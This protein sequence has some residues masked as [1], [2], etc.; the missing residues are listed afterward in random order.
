[1]D[2]QNGA[3][4]ISTPPHYVEVS[5]LGM[6]ST[7]YNDGEVH[8][9][10]TRSA[11]IGQWAQVEKKK[12]KNQANKK[13]VLKNASAE[14]KNVIS[15]VPTEICDERGQLFEKISDKELDTIGYQVDSVDNKETVTDEMG[16]EWEKIQV[17]LDTGAVDWVFKQDAAHGFKLKESAASKNNIP[18]FAANGTSIKKHGQR[19]CVGFSGDWVPLAVNVNV[20]EV[21][22]NLGGGMPIIEA[23]NRIVLDKDGSF[24]ENKR[25]GSRIKVNH[26]KGAFTFDFWVPAPKSNHAPSSRSKRTKN[27]NSGQ[28]K[29]LAEDF[30]G[31]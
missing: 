11:S 4:G 14:T 19:D 7:G 28:F 25:T 22:S 2:W 23:D 16:V 27:P 17:K 30:G 29:I 8:E 3:G 20:A 10:T 26:E 13:V 12:T 21:R 18:Y 1:M 6:R 15:T 5:C 9:V 24:I 31:R